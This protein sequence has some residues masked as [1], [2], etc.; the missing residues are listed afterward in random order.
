MRCGSAPTPSATRFT[1]EAPRKSSTSPSATKCGANANIT[2]CRWSS[3]PIPAASAVKAKGGIDSLYAVDYAARVACEMGADVIKLN[4]PVWKPDD[5]AKLP[6]ALQH[7]SFDDIEGLRKVVKS[8]G[9]SLVLVSGGS[10]MG[11]E[12]T[13]AQSHIAM[14]AGC[15]GLIFGRNMWQR[16]W[17]RPSPWLADP[18]RD[19]G[20]RPTTV[21]PRI[22]RSKPSLRCGDSDASAIHRM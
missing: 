5:A 10:K 4:E 7:A 13:I 11:D 19:G 9:R 3:W 21:S 14:A 15:V 20:L 8:A 1:S 18:R 16:K 17:D 6:K 22:M 12:A 2:A